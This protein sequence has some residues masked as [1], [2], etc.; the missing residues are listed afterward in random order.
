MSGAAGA[1]EKPLATLKNFAHNRNLAHSPCMQKSRLTGSCSTFFCYLLLGK[2]LK[3]LIIVLDLIS[4]WTCCLFVFLILSHGPSYH[5]N[6][7]N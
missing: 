7:P 5:A 1:E 4:N 2:Y 3:K 6:M